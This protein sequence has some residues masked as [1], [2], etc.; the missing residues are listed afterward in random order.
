MRMRRLGPL[1][2]PFGFVLAISFIV[3]AKFSRSETRPGQLA[4]E[5]R[6]TV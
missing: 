6:K 2:G 3:V 5:S 4:A 1:A